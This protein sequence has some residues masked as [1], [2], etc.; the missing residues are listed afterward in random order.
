MS[1]IQLELSFSLYFFVALY[2]HIM[3]DN[4][5]I[6]TENDGGSVCKYPEVACHEI[7]EDVKTHLKKVNVYMVQGNVKSLFAN[8]HRIKYLLSQ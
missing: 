8:V 3:K 7:D 4:S 5:S 6:K 2:F 1:C